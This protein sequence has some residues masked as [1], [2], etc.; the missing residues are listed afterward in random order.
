MATD[1]SDPNRVYMATGLY[2]Q[3]WGATA[4]ILASIDKGNTWQTTK[5]TIKLG[6]NEDGRSTGERLQV[7]P[8]LGNILYLGSS[9]DGLWKS[10]DY[11]ASWNKVNTFPVTSSP[12]GSGGIS[13]VL[14][15]KNS[16]TPGTATNT[17]YVGVVTPGKQFLV[18]RLILCH[19]MLPF[20]LMVCSTL[21]IPMVP[22]QT[23]S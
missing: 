8:N 10:L 16:S 6:G 21:L 20:Q 1:P 7:D 11:G 22:D 19:I 4:A 12:I 23:A 15:D 9:T 3:S 14:F 13:F 18:N 2:T 5:L 17:I